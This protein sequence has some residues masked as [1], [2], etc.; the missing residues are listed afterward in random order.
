MELEG[1][2]RSHA[3]IRPMSAASSASRTRPVALDSPGTAETPNRSPSALIP[4]HH[5]RSSRKSA[6]SVTSGPSIDRARSCSRSPSRFGMLA[7]IHASMRSIDSGCS[8][9]DPIL[10]WTSSSSPVSSSTATGA[11]WGPSSPRPGDRSVGSGWHSGLRI[12]RKPRCRLDL[13]HGALATEC[14]PVRVETP[15]DPPPAGT[16][17]CGP[18]AE[19]SPL[20]PSPRTSSRRIG[21][22]GLDQTVGTNLRLLVFSAVSNAIDWDM[23]DAAFSS[24]WAS[25]FAS[26]A[27][28]MRCLYAM[29]SKNRACRYRAIADVEYERRPRRRHA[30][31]RPYSRTD[32]GF[33]SGKMAVALAVTRE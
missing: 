10:E 4:T 11:P 16:F 9:T 29:L 30:Q 13:A 20:P 19:F 17:G 28:E 18:Q 6:S 21:G 22:D 1:G 26:T 12:R 33:S 14:P 3:S 32:Q 2:A 25:E 31:S 5:G 27:P 23:I 8:N 7:A 15:P 24:T